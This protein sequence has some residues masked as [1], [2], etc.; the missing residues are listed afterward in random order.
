MLG[1]YRG[2]RLLGEA[3]HSPLRGNEL[4]EPL[5]FALT[6]LEPQLM[7]LTGVAVERATGPRNRFAQTFPPFLDLTAAPFQNA[8]PR[9]CRSPVEERQVYPEAVVG[10]VVRT[11]VRHQLTEAPAALVG[12]LV[13]APGPPDRCAGRGGILGNQPF[14]LHAPQGRVERSIGKRPERTE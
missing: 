12:Q 1:S 14:G 3:G 7:K 5:D 8:H 10:V 2:L 6:G 11:G 13:H 4:V 9:L